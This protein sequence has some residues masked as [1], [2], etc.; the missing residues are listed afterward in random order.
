MIDLSIDNKNKIN[1]KSGFLAE[2]KKNKIAYLFI[3]PFYILFGIF[4]IFPLVFAFWLTFHNWDGIGNITFSGVTNYILLFKDPLFYKSLYNTIII[5][6]LAHIPMLLLA[7]M[8]AFLLN[9]KMVKLK[10]FFRT[11]YFAPVITSSVAVSLIFLT[12]Y[13][14]H[15]GLINVLLNMLHIKSIN[16]LAGNGF[17]IKPAIILLFIWRWLGWNM[18]IYYAGLQSIPQDI[19]EA[20]AIDGANNRQIFFKVVIPLMMPIIL[21]TVIMSTIGGLTIFDEPY[22]LIGASGGANYSGLTLSTY[23]Y[24]QAFVYSHFGY[25]S[26][27]GFIIS[28]LIVIVSLINIKIFGKDY[29]K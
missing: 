11:I 28:A 4:G 3:S 12:L 14:F 23:L 10:N 29:T 17:W 18:V 13:G 26:T 16:W 5:A 2:M 22:M 7:L 9:S 27:F 20:A 19:F 1:N 8:I 25:A 6:I 24:S 21:Y 15:Y